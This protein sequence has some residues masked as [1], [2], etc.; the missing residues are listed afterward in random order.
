MSLSNDKIDTLAEHQSMELESASDG[1]CTGSPTGEHPPEL[2]EAIVHTQP[3]DLHVSTEDEAQEPA[4]TNNQTTV[5]EPVVDDSHKNTSAGEGPPGPTKADENHQHAD[6]NNQEPPADMPET[7]HDVDPEGDVIFELDGGVSIRVASAVLRLVS[8]YFKTKLFGPFNEGQVERS[9]AKPQR[10]PLKDLDPDATLRLFCLINHQPDPEAGWELFRV[11]DS[12][13]GEEVENG[14]RRLL[15]LAVVANYFGCAHSLTKIFGSLLNQF[16]A[17]RVRSVISFQTTA[18]L[19]AAAYIM[20]SSQYFRLFTKRL[21]TDHTERFEDIELPA[22]VPDA[23]ITELARQSTCAWTQLATMLNRFARCKCTSRDRNCYEATDPHIVQNVTTFAL[24]LETSW[25]KHRSEGIS[26]R[27]LLVGIYDLE[28]KFRSAWCATHKTR[29]ED[30]IG[31]MEFARLCRKIDN[32]AEGLCRYCTSRSEGG[33]A[34]CRCSW[35]STSYRSEKGWVGGDSFMIGTV[36]TS[37]TPWG[38]CLA[39][40][41]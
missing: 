10:L 5:Q 1:L 8:Q 21:V 7:L 25:T 14:A 29:T 9:T 28:E 24:P 19:A 32:E 2:T 40:I 39:A 4:A 12:E 11:Y 35:S 38:E 17:P 15:D 3:S 41:S 6:T 20:E 16:I 23:I 34:E 31:P 13:L 22:E 36:R 27:R 30:S 33:T 26:L 18:D 37:L